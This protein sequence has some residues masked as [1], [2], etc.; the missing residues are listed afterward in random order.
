MTHS[1]IGTELAP[2]AHVTVRP[3]AKT[4]GATLSTPVPESCTQAT[5]A[6]SSQATIASQPM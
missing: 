1:E 6:A 3:L 4:A 5:S 2:R